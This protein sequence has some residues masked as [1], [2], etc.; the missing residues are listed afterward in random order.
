MIPKN[1]FKYCLFITF[2]VNVN[3]NKQKT[4]KHSLH[5]YFQQIALA[6]QKAE[7][8]LKEKVKENKRLQENF[9][10]LK[11]S[12]ESLKKEVFGNCKAGLTLYFYPVVI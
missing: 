7:T 9:N 12:N 4:Q 3:T 2:A 5:L 8:L 1:F 11:A 6:L 10:T